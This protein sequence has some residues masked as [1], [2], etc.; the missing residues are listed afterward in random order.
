M[1]DPLRRQVPEQTCVEMD[2]PVTILAVC[3]MNIKMRNY[4]VTVSHKQALLTIEAS[5]A[6]D[7]AGNMSFSI[8]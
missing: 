1:A 6:F 3:K 5:P 2:L 4:F 7:L 8:E